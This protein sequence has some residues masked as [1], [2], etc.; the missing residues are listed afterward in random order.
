[1]PPSGQAQSRGD[2]DTSPSQAVSPETTGC[3]PNSQLWAEKRELSYW[4]SP[5]MPAGEP[6]ELLLPVHT[7][8]RDILWSRLPPLTPYPHPL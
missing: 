3:P 1:M 8:F 7:A 6:T 4:L 2:L 5:I